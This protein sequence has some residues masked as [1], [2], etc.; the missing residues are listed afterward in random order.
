MD[1]PNIHKLKIE[2]IN[3][4]S[5]GS[6]IRQRISLD[7]FNIRAQEMTLTHRVG[8]VP[9]LTINAMVEVEDFETSVV[10]QYGNL[11]AIAS[12]ISDGQFYALVRMWCNRR[13]IDPCNIGNC[14]DGNAKY[15]D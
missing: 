14:F 2:Q 13:G 3:D 8:D 4:G 5:G 15:R 11:E 1:T 7:D 9:R 12:T 10:V 6:L